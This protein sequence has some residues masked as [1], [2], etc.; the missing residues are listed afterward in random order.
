MTQD[1]GEGLSILTAD[2]LPVMPVQLLLGHLLDSR[3][4]RGLRVVFRSTASCPNQL[5]EVVGGS[6]FL[7]ADCQLLRHYFLA[8]PP[9]P[10]VQVHQGLP[11]ASKCL[12]SVWDVM[13]RS[14]WTWE[15]VVRANHYDSFGAWRLTLPAVCPPV[16]V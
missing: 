15:R 8:L 3:A 7:L 13:L 4:L 5:G 11:H 12:P 2:V 10:R 14:F 6:T 9:V 16:A 1:V